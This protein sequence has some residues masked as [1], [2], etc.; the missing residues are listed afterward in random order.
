MDVGPCHGEMANEIDRVLILLSSHLRREVVR[1]CESSEHDEVIAV[2]DL[3][4]SLDQRVSTMDR[5]RLAVELHHVHLP[6]LESEGWI[7]FDSRTG[8]IRYYGY[9][10]AEPYLIE[11]ADMFDR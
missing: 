3:L 11:T 6:H 7:E 9:D 5:K 10:C 1:Y 8:N 2:D 4:D